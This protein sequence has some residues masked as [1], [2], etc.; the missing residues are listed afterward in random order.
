MNCNDHKHNYKFSRR[1][2][3][4]KTSLGLGALTVGSLINPSNL[5]SQNNY[6]NNRL[7]HFPPK[8]KRVIYL[9]QSGAPSQ[10]DLFDYKP[11]LNKLN[12]TELPDS[13]RGGQRLTG[14]SSGQASFPLAGSVFKFKQFGKSGAWMSE[15]M[16]YTSQ[17]VDDLASILSNALA[18]DNISRLLKFEWV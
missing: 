17:I 6:I 10:L 9:L 11:L 4:T 5:F 12:G 1:D 7:P 8:A 13:V 15:L 16:P 18:L 14:M 3:L 2:F